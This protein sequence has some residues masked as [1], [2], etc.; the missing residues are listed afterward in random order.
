MAT[1]RETA[2]HKDANNSGWGLRTPLARHKAEQSIGA[3]DRRRS[4][5]LSYAGAGVVVSLSAVCLRGLGLPY[6][7]LQMASRLKPSL[8]LKP[9]CP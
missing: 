2:V 7:A 1:R 5:E 4:H 8:R 9:E 3:G 6:E